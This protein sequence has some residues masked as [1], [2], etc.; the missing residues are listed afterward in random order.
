LEGGIKAW[1]EAGGQVQCSGRRCLPLDR[2]VQ[3][4]VGV[5]L[6]LTTLLTAF[7]SPAFLWLT[8]FIGIGLIFA[9]LSGFCGLAIVLSKMPWNK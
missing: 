9:G 4:S 3:F 6:L 7:V 5:L 1:S 8:G 2:Q